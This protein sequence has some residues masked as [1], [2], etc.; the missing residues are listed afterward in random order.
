MR[1]RGRTP[2]LLDVSTAR[3]A[4][5]TFRTALVSSFV[6]ILVAIMALDV[7]TREPKLR[8]EVRVDSRP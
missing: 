3:V 1:G 7:V 6:A 4:A 2:T 5:K 8:Q